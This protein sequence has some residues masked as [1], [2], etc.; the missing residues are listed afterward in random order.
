MT[1]LPVLTFH[2]IHEMATPVAVDLPTFRGIVRRLASAG[3]RTVSAGDALAFARGEKTLPDRSLLV[4][5]DDGYASVLEQAA[6]ILREAGFGALIFLTTG[7]LGRPTIFPGDSLCP[8]ERAL[9]WDD[10]R[11]LV[12]S[13]FEIGSHAETHSDLRALDDAA[14]VRE[15]SGSRA[16]L[17]Q[18]LSTPVRVHAYPF[19]ACD[20]R[21]AAACARV[22]DGAF[23]TRLDWVAAGDDV[24]LLP[25]LDAHYLRFLSA[26]GDLGSIATRAWVGLRRL[27]RS[28]RSALGPKGPAS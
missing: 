8:A 12:R 15:L 25:R 26:R 16:E 24:R 23:S 18:K 3:W 28:V 7:L 2:A 11:E 4:T 22:Y 19:G 20:A 21:V 27:G 5:F 17:E 1:R 6:P 13:G 10:A 9:G 14:L